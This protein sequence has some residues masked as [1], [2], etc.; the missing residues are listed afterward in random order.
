MG[1]IKKP[2]LLE[3]KEG[4]LRSEIMHTGLQVWGPSR[5]SFLKCLSGSH[6]YNSGGSRVTSQSITKETHPFPIAEVEVWPQRHHG[7]NCYLRKKIKP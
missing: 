7:Q 4:Q 1:I 5:G 3:E 2:R 6:K